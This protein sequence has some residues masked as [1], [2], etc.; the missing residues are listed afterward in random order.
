MIILKKLKHKVIVLKLTNITDFAYKSIECRDILLDLYAELND[1]LSLSSL[2]A[3][4]FY[5]KSI[6]TD[7]LGE[8]N[9]DFEYCVLAT[10][11]FIMIYEHARFYPGYDFC[12]K[13]VL[14]TLTEDAV[15]LSDE[16]TKAVAMLLLGVDCNDYIAPDQHIDIDTNIKP[17]RKTSLYAPL[18]IMDAVNLIETKFKYIHCFS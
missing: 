15:E 14:I 6:L 7:T 3:R 9:I 1:N 13:K 4:L 8:K 18:N 12:F 2:K 16:N 11:Y 10:N 5:T 17:S